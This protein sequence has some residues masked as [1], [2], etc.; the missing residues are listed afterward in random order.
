MAPTTLV[1]QQKG[2]EVRAVAAPALPA[3]LLSYPHQAG[4]SLGHGDSVEKIRLS[5]DLGPW[6]P[7][8]H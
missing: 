4:F 2:T 7:L 3:P 8:K 5:L 6:D 1:R